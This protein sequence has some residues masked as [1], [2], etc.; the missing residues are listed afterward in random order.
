MSNVL[1]EESSLQNIATAIRAKNGSSDTYTPSEMSTAISNIPTGGSIDFAYAKIDE[2]KTYEATSNA[3]I[4]S[5]ITDITLQAPLSGD[6]SYLFI[7]CKNL[8][9][10][11]GLDISDATKLLYTFGYCT[12]LITIPNINPSKVWSFESTFYGCTILEN[13]PVINMSNIDSATRLASMFKEC[14]KLTDTSLNNILASL[15]TANITLSYGR[16]LNNIG[17]SQTQAETC[18]TLSNWAALSAKGWT[19]GY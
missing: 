4:K 13:F 6:L 16:N 11:S 3:G 8:E 7:Y 12:S 1:V 18:T 2:T 19:T 17:L 14:P 9:T 5:L 10:I 15:D